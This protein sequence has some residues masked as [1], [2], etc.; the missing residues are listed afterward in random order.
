MNIFLISFGVL[1]IIINI[2]A[3]KKEK[4]TFG[5]HLNT[6]KN[7]LTEVDLRIGE[8]K[9][10]FSETIL[11]L[12]KE[13]RDLSEEN[14]IIKDKYSEIINRL[15]ENNEKQC[16]KNLKKFEKNTEE[17]IVNERIDKHEEHFDISGENKLER[18][19]DNE[20]SKNNNLND[21]RKNSDSNNVKITEIKKLLDHNLTVDKIAEKLN[22]GKG[23]VLLIKDLYID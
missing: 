20:E 18:D 4:K 10:E 1:L 21:K 6:A 12:Q 13:I 17:I 2:M 23:E 14:M 16:E 8:L 15:P 3:I 7:D 9:R 5:S 22:I 19:I 11:D